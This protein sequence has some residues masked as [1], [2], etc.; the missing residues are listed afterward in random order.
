MTTGAENNPAFEAVVLAAGSGSR[1][2]GGKLLAA[3]NAGVL[4]EGALAAALAAPARSVTVVVGADSE[5]VA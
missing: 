5:A 3:W 2:G 4:L 1:F